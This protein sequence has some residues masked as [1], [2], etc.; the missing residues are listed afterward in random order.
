MSE[1]RPGNQKSEMVI[2]HPV[3]CIHYC[4]P[5]FFFLLRLSDLISGESRQKMGAPFTALVTIGWDE[6]VLDLLT[7]LQ[8]PEGQSSVEPTFRYVH[9]LLIF[10]RMLLRVKSYF[11]SMLSFL[12]HFLYSGL[13]R[14]LAP[15]VSRQPKIRTVQRMNTSY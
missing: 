10:F 5:A 4:P 2:K 8:A 14:L 15:V 12:H 9:L 11:C 1:A 3:A 13:H 6:A 7:T